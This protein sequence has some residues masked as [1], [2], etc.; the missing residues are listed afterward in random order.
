MVSVLFLLFVNC[1]SPVAPAK[2]GPRD[3]TWTRTTLG[4]GTYQIILSEVWGSSANDVYVVGH[5]G[6]TVFDGK[7]WHFNGSV[8]SDITTKYKEAFNEAFPGR[9]TFYWAPAGVWGFGPNDVWIVGYR[10][11]SEISQEHKQG[12][13]IRYNGSVWRETPIPGANSLY[14]VWGTSPNDVWAAG[15]LGRLYHFD[16]TGWAGYQVSDSVFISTYSGSVGSNM[17]TT[18]HHL[19]GGSPHHSL[20]EWN[21][22]NWSIAEVS[23]GS[24]APTFDVAHVVD[25]ML[26]SAVYDAVGSELRK[27]IAPGSWSPVFTMPNLRMIR[28]K[29]R[30]GSDIIAV[31]YNEAIVHYNGSDAKVLRQTTDSIEYADLFLF[32]SEVFAIGANANRTIGFVIHG[33]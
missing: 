4:D 26:Y 14:C 27:R 28:A 1:K 17:Y 6:S 21:G 23:S 7:I 32:E 24:P 3:Y 13:V 22:S 33:K 11:T 5:G 30:S 16:G 10:D 19:A 18:G 2:K 31:G 29:G 9:S 15:Q 25:G 12:F 20:L 8:W